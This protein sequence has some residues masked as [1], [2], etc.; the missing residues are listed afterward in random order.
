MTKTKTK[1]KSNK[2][3]ELE[4]QKT[5]FQAQLDKE[6]EK[7]EQLWTENDQLKTVISNMRDIMVQA[8]EEMDKEDSNEHQMMYYNILKENLGS[9]LHF[10]SSK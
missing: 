7:N 5:Y 9:S 1:T 3:E 4:K 10:F 8:R 6:K 2:N